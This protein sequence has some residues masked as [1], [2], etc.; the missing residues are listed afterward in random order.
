MA[1]TPRGSTAGRGAQGHRTAPSRTA[2]APMGDPS[3][4]RVSDRNRA[5]GEEK[6]AVVATRACGVGEHR[7]WGRPLEAG[8]RDGIRRCQSRHPGRG[9]RDP[10]A[11]HS[12]SA[13]APTCGGE[14]A[15]AHG[16][17]GPARGQLYVG[18]QSPAC[19]PTATA[20]TKRRDHRLAEGIAWQNTEGEGPR[21]VARGARR[22]SEKRPEEEEEAL[23]L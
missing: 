23:E 2:P 6:R 10:R 3:E 21:Q 1:E 12:S 15:Q 9:T 16:G 17:A 7:S 19:F 11:T 4:N 14:T 5:D 20:R 8:G 18:S 13:R 22:V